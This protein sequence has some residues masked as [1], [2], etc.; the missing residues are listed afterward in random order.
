[1]KYASME[2]IKE[3]RQTELSTRIEKCYSDLSQYNMR[4]LI[5]KSYR[6]ISSLS[7]TVWF[8]N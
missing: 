1:M 7:L 6:V 5:N 3:F 8:H 2:E 4:I